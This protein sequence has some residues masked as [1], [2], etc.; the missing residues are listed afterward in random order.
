LSFSDY[1]VYVDESG[2]HSLVSIDKNY[3]IFV[4]V[5]VIF[6][7]EDYIE[8]VKDFKN[9]KFKYFGYDT[10]ILHE[11]E[12]RREKGPFKFLKT[13]EKK[14]SFLYEL[15]KIIDKSKCTVLS[16][17]IDKNKLI[18]KYASPTN[19]YNLSLKFLLERLYLLLQE[20]HQTDKTTHIIVEARGRKEDEELK[21]EFQ[22]IINKNNFF[23]KVLPFEL[24]IAHKQINSDG[25]QLADLMAR[26]IG[27]KYLKPKQ[28]NLAFET[29]KDKF[30]KVNGKYKNYGIKIFP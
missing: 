10:V 22:N 16:S 24:I 15:T 23:N 26:P 17:I 19:P 8:L 6:K 7:K 9:F 14:E 3:P 1:I 13:K 4:L 20:N 21:N 12:I 29:I 11:N 27:R 5:F 2:D 18:T 30:R 25:M 28:T